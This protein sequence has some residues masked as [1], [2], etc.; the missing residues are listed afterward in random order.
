ML[1]VIKI[2]GIKISSRAGTLGTIEWML[3]NVGLYDPVPPRRPR[4]CQEH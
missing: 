4:H 3:S 2:A 1:T